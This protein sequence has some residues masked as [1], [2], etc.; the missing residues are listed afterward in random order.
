MNGRLK[1]AS[2]CVAPTV[3]MALPVSSYALRAAPETEF[4]RAI[5]Y[6]FF[7][8]CIETIH[9]GLYVLFVSL[10]VIN[11]MFILILTKLRRRHGL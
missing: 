2:L 10:E 6:G 4:L 8:F 3:E 7:E 5:F 9:L 1:V 11:E